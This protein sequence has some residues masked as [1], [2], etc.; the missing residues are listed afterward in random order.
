[1]RV[2]NEHRHSVTLNFTPRLL[3][4]LIIVDSQIQ[5]MLS[6]REAEIT[7]GD[8]GEHS[9][10]SCHYT[11]NAVDIRTPT[12]DTSKAATLLARCRR[13]LPFGYD[14]VAETTHW[15]LEYDPKVPTNYYKWKEVA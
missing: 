3:A 15:H 7:C 5:R 2:A 4:G 9:V 11:G 14:L 1:M 12:H 6:G 8:N 13:A 10:G